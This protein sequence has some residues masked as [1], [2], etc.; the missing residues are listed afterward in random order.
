MTTY[1]S[2]SPPQLEPG[3][4]CSGL[5]CAFTSTLDGLLLLLWIGALG[6]TLAALLYLPRARSIC[7]RERE[8]TRDEAVAFGRFADR[9]EGI[10]E[11]SKRNVTTQ[12]VTG[13]VTSATFAP[14][15]D[16]RGLRE[17]RDAYRET[18]MSV[19]HY[20]EEYD[21]P[22]AENV[23]EEFDPEVAAVL[24]DG[25]QLTP[26]VKR[27]VVQR[28]YDARNRRDQFAQ[29]LERE[30]EAI[31][32]ADRRLE[33]VESTLDRLNQRSLH[34]RTYAELEDA[35]FQLRDLEDRIETILADR[36]ETIRT[37]GA[38]RHRFADRWTMYAYLY[39]ELPTSHPAL[40]EGARLLDEVQTSQHRVVRSLSSRV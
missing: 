34:D 37:I 14:T 8:R 33:D 39:R 5:E 13:P 28:A 29:V 31:A 27:A 22:L 17:I 21:E 2:R 30:A 12:T 24:T 32:D 20:E 19:P 11:S 4:A 36:Q 26:Q 16:S 9:V 23:A 35:W 25:D 1:Y 38:A 3:S 7:D 6:I 40:S 18:V 15:P 10:D